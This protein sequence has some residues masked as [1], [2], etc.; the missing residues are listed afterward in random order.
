MVIKS[1]P[2]HFANEETGQESLHATLLTAVY[3]FI[4][5]VPFCNVK[6]LQVPAEASPGILS[7]NMGP[8][9]E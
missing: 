7:W 9:E 6:A 1:R 3:K 4:R 8:L 5:S 2:L